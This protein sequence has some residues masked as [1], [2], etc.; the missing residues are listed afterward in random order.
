MR[1]E[2]LVQATSND[3][4]PTADTISPQSLTLVELSQEQ[5]DSIVQ[6]VPGGARN[7]LDIYPLSPLQEGMLFHHRLND[8]G[9][10]YVLSTLFE[11]Q[12]RAHIDALINALQEVINYHEVLRTGVLWD[13]LP[14]PV[15]V[16][17]RRAPLPV[18]AQVLDAS[19][20]SLQ[21][22]MEWMRPG[23]RHLDVRHAPLVQLHIA[24]DPHSHRWYAV[25]F[26]HHLVCDHQSLRRLVAEVLGHLKGNDQPRPPAAAFRSY[27]AHV[28][29]ST[30][31]DDAEAFFRSKLADFSEPTAP[32]GQSDV[33]GDGSHIEEARL[34]L[35][36]EL[37]QKIRAQA[38]QHGV[39]VARL[40]HAA[41]ALVVACTSGQSDV[42]FGTVLRGQKHRDA[43]AQRVLGMLVNTLPLRLR[44]QDVSVT[45]LVEQTN[46]E[47]A[48][49]L[50]HKET[51]LV[52][53]QRCSGIDG[54]APL[55]S[56]LLNFRHSAPE[57]V[58]D[59]SDA[60]GVRVL[61]RAE[62][63]SNYPV[64]VIVDDLG[65]GF[66]LV[67]QADRRI[68]PMRM[69]QYLQTAIDS[70][71]TALKRAPQTPALSLQVLPAAEQR[72]VIESFNATQAPYPR[73][74]L[75]HELFEEQVR[76]TPTATAVVC[77]EES[78]TYAQLNRRANRLARHLRR[79]GVAPDRLVGVCI[80]RSLDMVVGLL[81][82]LKA[83]GAYL[84]LDPS[85]PVERLQ[86]ILRD[87]RPVALLTRLSLS[88]ISAPGDCQ[89]I[90][91]QDVADEISR[92]AQ[93]N[94]SALE[95]GLQS[96]HLSYVIY[97][98]G[99]T[100][101]P[102][103]VAIEHR[104]VVNLIEWHC[105]TFDVRQGDRCSCLAAV[106]FDAA[107]WEMWPA[108][109]RGATLVLASPANSVDV[110]ALLNWWVAQ[111]LDISFLPTPMAELML[112]RNARNSTL[113]TLLVGGDSL[114]SRPAAESFELIN[115][116]GPTEATVLAT[117]GRIHE[118]DSVIHIGR[119]TSNAQIYILNRNQRAVPVG[120]VGEIYIGGAGV[121]RGYLNRPEMT[122]QWFV[123]DP[124]RA[125]PQA[126]MYRTGD[127]G[128]WR[129]DGTI[130]HLGRSDHQVKIRGFRIELGEIEAQMM[131][132]PLVKEAVVIVR[133]DAPGDRR[134]V[135]YSVCGPASSGE[136]EASADVLRA[137]LKAVLPDYMVPGAFVTLER[138]PLTE[139]GKVARRALPPPGL[140][141][142]ATSSY[143]TPRGDVEKVLAGL[144]QELLCVERVG[145]KDNFFE[146]GGH[147]LLAMQLIARIH[148]ALSLEV[149]M[150]LP[151]EY[152][153]VEQLSAQIVELR[154]QRMLSRITVGDTEFEA[155][156]EDIASMS[157][158]EAQ[159]LLEEMAT[160]GE[161]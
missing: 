93:S 27:V 90:A 28:L 124:F 40:F 132:H 46:H 19:R 113:R 3:P 61:V 147:S 158:A 138:L 106:G 8:K 79:R 104:N 85:Y 89:V 17:Y 137:H 155:L 109:S 12:S 119:P 77:D 57:A 110:D 97:T 101:T 29:A 117:S 92:N 5:V 127:L 1:D 16:V 131:R 114:R 154:R 122:A 135:A 144:W 78:L 87:S 2:I 102:K 32:F 35:A 68:G 64:S 152:P 157:E 22:L 128:R 86:Y 136:P 70:V 153:T 151:F 4:D 31:T 44:L 34:A 65:E 82:I 103:G 7:V 129:P 11:A 14:Q 146:L 94:L 30:K 53:A 76:R 159:A 60:A 108:L 143:E 112:S 21:Q 96:K 59:H 50:N 67:A 54:S 71:A 133:E 141:A 72:Q 6:T 145:R 26:V 130:E 49:V 149:P 10:T 58:I 56:S 37:A 156:L 43:S 39:S 20:D 18:E 69:M 33:H 80:E 42:V 148:A 83:G 81:A 105:A 95:I 150:R 47:L 74:R 120:V 25:L 116:Y 15:Q 123:S 75:V 98:S 62:A 38:A 9:D 161:S 84:P 139:N 66:E 121:A 36:P 125:D 52:L 134:L 41:W 99:S 13:G 73:D 100:G 88:G 140:G 160:E 142:Y 111:P 45:T 107:A 23:R 63:W 126:R 48:Q 118:D 51:S 24:A 55:F 115:N 91:L